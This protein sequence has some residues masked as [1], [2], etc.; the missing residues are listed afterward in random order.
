MELAVRSRAARIAGLAMLIGMLPAACLAPQPGA[1]PL[2]PDDFLLG[3]IP[4]ESDSVEIRMTFGDPDSVVVSDNPFDAFEPIVSWHYDGF[5]VRF[6]GS[7]MPVGYLITG[8][9]ERT[10][11][12]IRVGDAG[13]EVLR[14][15]G[16][17]AYRHDPVWTY[18]DPMD[19]EGIHVLEFLVEEDTVRRI[20]I[21][22]GN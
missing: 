1:A 11:R 10:L 7:A 18:V 14:R 20:H 16:A 3:G 22:R 9:H 21:G 8:G 17:P 12:G 13:E 15:Y 19:V 5:V 6:S 4:P 2:E